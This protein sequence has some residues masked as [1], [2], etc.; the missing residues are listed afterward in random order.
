MLCAVAQKNHGNG[1]QNPMAQFQRPSPR[2]LFASKYVATPLRLYD[3]SP[4]TDGAAAVDLTAKKP[5]CGWLASVKEPARSA[6]EEEK[7]LLHF[8]PPVGSGASLSNG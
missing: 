3:C 1:A 6:C 5:T 4:I 8:Q 7:S 2:N